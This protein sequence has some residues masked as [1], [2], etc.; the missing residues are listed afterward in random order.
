[1]H[2][3]FDQVTLERMRHSVEA[4]RT[5]ETNLSDSGWMDADFEARKETFAHISSLPF[6][7]NSVA[8]ADSSPSES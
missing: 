6:E 7:A 5:I 2:Q 8:V 3:G 4:F 1:L